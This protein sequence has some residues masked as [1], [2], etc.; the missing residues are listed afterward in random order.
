[1]PKSKWLLTQNAEIKASGI[2]AWTL[3]AFVVKLPDGKGFNVC[4]S[5]GIC[6]SM[7]YA[8]AG[9]FI[10]APVRQ[11]HMEK[12]EMVLNDMPGWEAR[13]NAELDHERYDERHV[14]IHD[15]GDFFSAAYLEAWLRIATRH[16]NVTF[17]CYTKEVKLFK[18]R[19][20]G[21]VVLWDKIRKQWYIDQTAPPASRSV[22]SNF[23]FLYS[24]GGKLDYLI[25]KEVDRHCEV[26]HTFEA[27][28]EAGYDDQEEN[29]LMAIYNENNKVGVLQNNIPQ[30]IAKMGTRTFGSIQ[31]AQRERLA[32]RRHGKPV[33][34]NPE[35]DAMDAEQ[36]AREAL[37][38][39]GGTV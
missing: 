35:L 27:M 34:S 24:M 3:P 10:F 15:G 36:L 29:D 21:K 28:E 8:L 14:R 20:E 22:P 2:Y 33:E 17:Y 38:K 12:L 6:A 19:I 30:Y 26:F 39:E 7:C 23:R 4:P 13:M 9:K 25:D 31:E 5:A 1:V 11:A 16:P 32:N 37:A 18:E